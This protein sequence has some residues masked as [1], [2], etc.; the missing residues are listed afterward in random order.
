MM[1]SYDEYILF[2]YLQ[3]IISSNRLEE[4]RHAVQLERIQARHDDTIRRKFDECQAKERKAFQNHLDK[5]S[6]RMREL[7]NKR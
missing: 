5:M 3:R 7:A 1:W 4:L 2:L 6:M